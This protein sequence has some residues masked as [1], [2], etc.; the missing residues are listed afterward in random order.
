MIFSLKFFS[1][2][3]IRIQVPMMIKRLRIGL[4]LFAGSRW[5]SKHSMRM[6]QKKLIDSMLEHLKNKIFEL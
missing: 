3:N 2:K 1:K 6:M 4:N 5:P